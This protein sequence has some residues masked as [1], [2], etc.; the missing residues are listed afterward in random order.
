MGRHEARDL[1][2]AIQRMMKAL[3]NRAREGDEEAVMVLG[4]L[5][6]QASG[7]LTDGVTAWRAFTPAHNAPRNSWTD[8][9]RLLGVTRQSAQERFSRE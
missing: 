4:T 7:Y 2:G 9:G 6:K 8:V 1:Q 3:V 5:E